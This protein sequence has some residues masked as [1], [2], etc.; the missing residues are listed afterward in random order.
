MLWIFDL[1]GSSVVGDVK[2]L[3]FFLLIFILTADYLRNRRSGSFPPGPT[4]IPIIGNIFSLDHSRTHE[5]LTQ[6][7]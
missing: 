5:S 4:A 7:D 1:I 6:V 2:G 3:L